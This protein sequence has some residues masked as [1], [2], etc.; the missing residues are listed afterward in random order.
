MCG[1][2]WVPLNDAGGAVPE[3]KWI[4]NSFQSFLVIDP[5]PDPAPGE[6]DAEELSIEVRGQAGRHHRLGSADMRRPPPQ[7]MQ[8]DIPTLRKLARSGEMLLPSVAV[9][10][11]ALDELAERGLL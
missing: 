8:V 6:R 2:R 1:G 5:V 11:W 9:C 3:G 10:S 7:I 4:T